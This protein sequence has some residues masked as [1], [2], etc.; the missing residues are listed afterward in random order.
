MIWVGWSGVHAPHD[1]NNKT[2]M[3]LRLGTTGIMV[4]VN[5]LLSYSRL[6]TALFRPWRRRLPQRRSSSG[7][8]DRPDENLPSVLQEKPPSW[9]RYRPAW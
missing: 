6:S 4:M 8:G 3:V 9:P 5:L 2:H 7:K 1:Y